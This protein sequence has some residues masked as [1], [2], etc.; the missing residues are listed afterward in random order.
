M[1]LVG[2]VELN[3]FMTPETK[4]FFEEVEKNLKSKMHY[5]DAIELS[6]VIIGGNITPLISQAMAKYQEATHPRTELFAQEK[7][8]ELALLSMGVLWEE[9][10]FNPLESSQRE[11]LPEAIYFI[12]KYG[13]EENG[14]T[15]AVE[16]NA[17]V[18]GDVHSR[19]EIIKAILKER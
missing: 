14:L 13:K 17:L 11:L 10:Y 2:L 6:A 18:S 9:A 7:S 19:K 16:A 1:A 3:I 5:R 12:M 15:K 8:D 4:S